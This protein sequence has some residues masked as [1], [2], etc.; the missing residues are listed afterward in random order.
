MRLLIQSA[1]TFQFLHSSPVTGEVS[2]TPSLL[3][4]LEFGTVSDWEQ[5]QEMVEE[6]F[7]RGQAVVIDLDADR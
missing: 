5:A 2:F 3:T 1:R 7:D 6:W 4:A